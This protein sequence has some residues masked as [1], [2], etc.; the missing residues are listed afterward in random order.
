MQAPQECGLV[1]AD[2]PIKLVRGA[3]ASLWRHFT[4]NLNLLRAGLFVRQHK[5]TMLDSAKAGKLS[6]I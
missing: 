1:S 2:S 4:Q 5:N 6:S 3:P